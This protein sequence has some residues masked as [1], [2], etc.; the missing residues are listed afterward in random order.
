MHTCE[1]CQRMFKSKS[2]L[3]RHQKTTT[4]CL[5]KRGLEPA[6]FKC[7][8][9]KQYTRQHYLQLHQQTCSVDSPQNLRFENQGSKEED[10]TLIVANKSTEDFMLKV[11]DDY[12]DMIKDLQKQLSSKPTKVTNNNNN[13]VLN[14]LQP[15]TDEE[16]EEHA[17]K[18]VLDFILEGAKGFAVFANGYSFKD[19]VLCTDK[20]RQKLRYKDNDG[21]LVEDSGGH[22]LVQRFFQ[23]ISSRNEEIINAEYSILQ[24]KVETTHISELTDL[25]TKSTK[26]QDILRQCKDAA[27]GKDNELTQE[28]IKHYVKIL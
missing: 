8:C 11:I 22:K 25:L 10:T 23:A 4:K 24:Q 17:D 13:N 1:H 9:G 2:S 18:L 16:L 26:L 3:N 14:N 5:I 20:A 15:I 27:D 19:R 28:F 7:N 12:K 21:E 6:Y